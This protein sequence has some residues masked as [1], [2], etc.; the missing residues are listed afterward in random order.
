M[1]IDE[2]KKFENK[3]KMEDGFK[4]FFKK[5]LKELTN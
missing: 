1:N 3:S 2:K 5:S 4:R